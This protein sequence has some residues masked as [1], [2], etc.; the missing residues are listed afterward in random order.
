MGLGILQPN[1]R[2]DDIHANQGS[3]MDLTGSGKRGG[4]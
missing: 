4:S 3:S 1:L 2:R